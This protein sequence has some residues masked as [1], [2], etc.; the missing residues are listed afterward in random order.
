MNNDITRIEVFSKGID[1]RAGSA[2]KRLTAL[3]LADEKLELWIFDVYTI[4]KH[5]SS[6]ELINISS[7][8]ANPVTQT[9]FIRHQ[10]DTHVE[11]YKPFTFAIEI[12]FLPGVTD[13]VAHTT[14][15]GIE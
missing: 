10:S 9:A 12:G 13:N 1:A 11:R 4:H 14:R 6:D 2:K 8:L 15:E 3:G 7:L 5:F